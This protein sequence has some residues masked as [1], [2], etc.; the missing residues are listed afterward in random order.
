[1]TI[2]FLSGF[3]GTLS[4]AA[5]VSRK[6]M[7]ELIE[8]RR[9]F[10]SALGQ[11]AILII[12]LGI[13]LPSSDTAMWNNPTGI[14]VIFFLFPALLTATVAADAFAGESER[15]TLETLLATPISDASLFFGKAG[16]AVFY[17]FA[18]SVL[19]L[20]TGLV[21]TQIRFGSIERYVPWT[22]VAVAVG[23]ALVAAVFTAAVA[24]LVSTRYPVARAAEQIARVASIL[25]GALL[26]GVT[27]ALTADLG[28]TA[29]IALQG[30]LLLTGAIAIRLSAS[31]FRRDA[32]FDAR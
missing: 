32:I 16:W 30:V 27:H 10:R 31:R 17:A 4:D 5:I 28:W 7:L 11:T 2:P 29:V 12:F 19:A 22:A 15:G 21:T 24:I 23:D 8:D 1:M 6:E 26:I 14:A 3:W 18:V 13:Y 25:T 9:A 20:A